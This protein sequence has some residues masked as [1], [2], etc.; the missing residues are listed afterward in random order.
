MFYEGKRRRGLERALEERTEALQ[1]AEENYRSLV[2]SAEDFI[3]TV[4]EFGCLRSLNSFTANFLEEPPRSFSASPCHSS[5][6]KRLH[7]SSSS[8]FAWSF[9]PAKVFGM[10]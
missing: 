1:K 8:S 7:H 9:S 3:F 5:F 2:E 10:N 4:D 6:Q